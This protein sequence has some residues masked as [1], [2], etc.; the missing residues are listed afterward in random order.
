MSGQEHVIIDQLDTGGL[1]TSPVT[2]SG[3]SNDTSS[4]DDVGDVG[5]NDHLIIGRRFSLF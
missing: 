3:H 2:V 4:T 5:L 1:L